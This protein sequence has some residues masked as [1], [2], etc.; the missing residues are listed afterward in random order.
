MKIK[1]RPEDFVVREQVDIVA[2][3]SDDIGPAWPLVHDLSVEKT[4]M[5]YIGRA[6]LDSEGEPHSNGSNWILWA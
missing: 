6:A 4:G 2:G 1:V 3:S 5:E